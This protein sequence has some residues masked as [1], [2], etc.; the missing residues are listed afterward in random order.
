MGERRLLID[1]PAHQQGWAVRDGYREVSVELFSVEGAAVVGD[2]QPRSLEVG[3]V[4]PPAS[5]A[6]HETETR[7]RAGVA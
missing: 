7:A 2:E 6:R 5:R 3:G 4:K 1:V